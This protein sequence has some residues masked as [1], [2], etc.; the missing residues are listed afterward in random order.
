M[1]RLIFYNLEMSYYSLQAAMLP[2]VEFICLRVA[3]CE[4]FWEELS[5]AYMKG[6]FDTR[7]SHCCFEYMYRYM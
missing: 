4:A 2:S 5:M 7:G 1:S 3:Y 6:A